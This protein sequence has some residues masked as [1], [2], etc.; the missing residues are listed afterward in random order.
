MRILPARRRLRV[1]RI[2]RSDLSWPVS[3][4]CRR[5]SGASRTDVVNSMVGGGACGVISRVG[6]LAEQNSATT[7]SSLVQVRT[8]AVQN[9]R[10]GCADVD[11]LCGCDAGRVAH[12]RI[13][14]GFIAK[15][16]GMK[17]RVI[18]LCAD[19]SRTLSRTTTSA[20]SELVSLTFGALIILIQGSAVA[21]FIYTLF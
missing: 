8:L 18:G 14:Q 7:Q 4:R 17:K 21:P 16:A 9:R 20:A 12:A 13:R 5:P 6:A 10:T 1:R 19:I 11:F 15:S 2:A 3:L